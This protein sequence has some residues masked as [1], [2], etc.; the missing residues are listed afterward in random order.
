VLALTAASSSWLFRYNATR[1]AAKFW[2]PEVAQIIRDAPTVNLI[3]L[4]AT[5]ETKRLPLHF[6]LWSG[7][8]VKATQYYNVSGGPGLTHLRNALLED[9]NYIWPA[10]RADQTLD[11]RWM[12]GFDDESR[13][14]GAFV[15]FTEDCTHTALVDSDDEV[16]S[17]QPI[18]DG[19]ST[20]FAEFAANLPPAN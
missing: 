19:L 16:A 13:S 4:E 12:L 18:A 9:R 1:R 5:H 14:R 6:Q 2:G 17:C 10:Q 7:K 11:W 8:Q 15:L 20:M 3:R